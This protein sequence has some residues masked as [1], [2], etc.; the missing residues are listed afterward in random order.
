[1]ESVL[2][3]FIFLLL[4]YLHTGRESIGWLLYIQLILFR[5]MCKYFL[6]NGREVKISNYTIKLRYCLYADKNMTITKIAISL[7]ALYIGFVS[8]FEPAEIT[9]LRLL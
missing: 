5:Q 2:N 7:K 3:T 1:M 6:S 9:T 8:G 4:M